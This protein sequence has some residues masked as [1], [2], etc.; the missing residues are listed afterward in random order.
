[1]FHV[2][3]FFAAPLERFRFRR[4]ATA[5]GIRVEL[6][7]KRVLVALFLQEHRRP[8]EVLSE[9]KKT[10]YLLSS[11]KKQASQVAAGIKFHAAVATLTDTGTSEISGGAGL[12]T[13]A[14]RKCK[15]L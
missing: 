6:A 15:P 8:G 9:R 11:S 4:S 10:P 3:R 7:A 14:T 2:E 12:K 1:M 13:R 5:R